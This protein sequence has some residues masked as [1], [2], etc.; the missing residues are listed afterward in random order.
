MTNNISQQHDLAFVD[1][2]GQTKESTQPRTSKKLRQGPIS[3]HCVKRVDGVKSN[4][5][6]W[7][8]YI[9]IQH[10]ADQG[11]GLG[12]TPFGHDTILKPSKSGLDLIRNRNQR[13]PTG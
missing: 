6:L 3:V 8:W 7:G 10:K 12:C 2:V 13:Q 9:F 5:Y 4:C 11:Q 1:S